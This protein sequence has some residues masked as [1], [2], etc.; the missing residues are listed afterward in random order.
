M[1]QQHLVKR[2]KEGEYRMEKNMQIDCWD[3]KD[4]PEHRKN[5]CPAF[6]H[7]EGKKCWITTGTWCGGVKQ[8][9]MA[10]KIHKCRE[11]DFFKMRGGIPG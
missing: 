3:F 4:C 10:T 8:K 1:F 5:S 9:D 6:S 11:C 2:P 7:N